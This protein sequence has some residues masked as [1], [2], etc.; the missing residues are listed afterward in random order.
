VS[1]IV[2]VRT[3]VRDP[4]A[5]AA[6][7][8]R[9]GLPEPTHGTAEL[10]SGQAT[11]LLVKLPDWL[12]PLVCDSANGQVHYD[13]FNGAPRVKPGSRP[14]GSQALSAARPA[15]LLKR[16]SAGALPSGSLSSSTR[17]TRLVRSPSSPPDRPR[18][19]LPFPMNKSRS[20]S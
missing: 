1:H 18:R 8:R 6:A 11:G 2:T 13:N 10:F 19:T 12:Y 9:L 20:T 5:I 15:G 7:C 17:I 4:T 3:E 14:K 16:R